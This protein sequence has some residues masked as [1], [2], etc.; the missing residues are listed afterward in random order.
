M[1]SEKEYEVITDFREWIRFLSL[2]EDEKIPDD[3]K[4]ALFLRW[5]TNEIPDDLEGA[6]YALSDFLTCSGL[7]VGDNEEKVEKPKILAF[8]FEEDAGCIY[9]AFRECY[10]IDLQMVEYMHWWEFR[11]LF[12]WLPE[13]T[14]I[15]QRMMYRT[16]DA[17]AIK[18]NEERKRVRKIQKAIRLKRKE[19]K[20]SDYE[21]GDMF[22]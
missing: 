3:V 1:V 2:V 8:S 20:L 12:D 19:R 4:C 16:I 10:G 13:E 18:D 7:Y 6:I 17:S 9:A 14:E 21:I 15:K 5:F 11:T 22:A